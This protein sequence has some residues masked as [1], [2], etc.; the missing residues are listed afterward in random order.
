MSNPKEQQKSVPTPNIVENQPLKEKIEDKPFDQFINTH[1]IPSITKELDQHGVAL[2]AISLDLGIR[3]V[4]GGECWMVKGEFLSGKR[5]WIT[6]NSDKLTSQ[7]NIALAETSCEPSLLE[8][9]LIDERKIT[10]QLIT[11]R[12]LQ[13]LNGQKWLGQN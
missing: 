3:P 7:K 12:L 10:L 9:F 6:F 4:V 5:F 2:K 11:S 13:R 1:L 8:S